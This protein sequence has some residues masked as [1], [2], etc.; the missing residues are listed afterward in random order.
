MPNG[1]F[2]F[3]PTSPRGI[4][5]LLDRVQTMVLEGK[6]SLALQTLVDGNIPNAVWCRGKLIE[7]ANAQLFALHCFFKGL[8][9][10]ING[11]WDILFENKELL[12]LTGLGS[13]GEV[14]LQ[15]V[16]LGLLAVRAYC[17]KL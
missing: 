9:T 16:P 7:S 17:G 3:Y 13:F 14:K 2:K 12:T 5:A 6:F 1:S 4:T 15:C 11:S 8:S 10:M